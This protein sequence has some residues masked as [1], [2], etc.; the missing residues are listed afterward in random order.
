V[1]VVGGAAA[2]APPTE[3]RSSAA[4]WEY[5]AAGGSEQRTY[6][7]GNTAPAS[8]AA[9]AIYGCYYNGTGDCSG[10]ANIAPL[11]TVP[12]GASKAGQVDLAGNLW[13]WN[14][15]GY[16]SFFVAECND[17]TNL[18]ASSSRALRG[19]SF[20]SGAPSLLAANRGN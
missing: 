4:E 14:L 3:N 5:A 12:A 19:G 8:D 2:G 6:P 18:T 16:Q 10:I 11:G 7:R 1:G 17:C 20:R 9:L 15:D 13:E